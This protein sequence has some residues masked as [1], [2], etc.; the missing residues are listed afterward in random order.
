MASKV[1][2]ELRNGA[3]CEMSRTAFNVFLSLDKVVRF[4]R[5]DGWVCVESGP[6]RDLE[7]NSDYFQEADRRSFL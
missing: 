3:V 6:L 5:S 4:K 1:K 2:V 7:K